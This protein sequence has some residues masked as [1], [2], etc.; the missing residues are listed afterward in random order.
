M[1]TK[2]T[3]LPIVPSQDL[4]GLVQAVLT[5]IEGNTEIRYKLNADNFPENGKEFPVGRM[6]VYSV[7]SDFEVIDKGPYSMVLNGSSL[8]LTTQSIVVPDEREYAIGDAGPTENFLSPF[9]TRQGLVVVTALFNLV[10]H[11]GQTKG[12]PVDFFFKGEYLYRVEH[13]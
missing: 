8:H 12:H 1:Y 6:F 11:R 10:T 7:V 4:Y 9:A 13:P 3:V 5:Y 2:D